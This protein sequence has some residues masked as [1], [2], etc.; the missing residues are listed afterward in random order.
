MLIDL[1]FSAL[2]L[3]PQ[4]IRVGPYTE[5]FFWRDTSEIIEQQVS[6]LDISWC[7]VV[8]VLAVLISG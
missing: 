6:C 8:D 1:R 2:F 7:T 4:F 5:F 3:A